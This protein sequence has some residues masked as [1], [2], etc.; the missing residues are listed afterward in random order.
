MEA[1]IVGQPRHLARKRDRL[2]SSLR[3]AHGAQI[4]FLPHFAKLQIYTLVRECN[5]E[6]FNQPN[7]SLRRP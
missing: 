7:P 3:V 6:D 5:R 2:P 1:C 4:N